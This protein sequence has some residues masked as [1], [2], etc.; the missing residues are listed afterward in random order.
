MFKAHIYIFIQYI[1][2]YVVYLLA[3]KFHVGEG[4]LRGWLRKKYLRSGITQGSDYRKWLEDI[5]LGNEQS[6]VGIRVC[7]V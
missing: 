1:N 4:G 2:R 6:R 5:R 7:T 3:L